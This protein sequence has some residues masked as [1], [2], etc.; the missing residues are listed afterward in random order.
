MTAHYFSYR[1]LVAHTLPRHY[2]RLCLEGMSWT[3]IGVLVQAVFGFIDGHD[4]MMAG[5]CAHCCVNYML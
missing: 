2:L 1:P 4:T 3:N 5:A